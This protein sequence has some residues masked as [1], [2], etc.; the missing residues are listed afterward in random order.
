MSKYSG[1]NAQD[2]LGQGV[3][4]LHFITNRWPDITKQ[5]YKIEKLER[6]KYERTIKGSPKGLCRKR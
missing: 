5:S 2:L 6:K 4:I 1:L 3:L